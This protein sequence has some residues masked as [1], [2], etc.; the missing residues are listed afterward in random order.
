MSMNIEKIKCVI[1]AA[2]MAAGSSL[3]KERMV[4]LF[5]EEEKVQTADVTKALELLQ[6]E[7]E[8]RGVELIEVATGY[9]YQARQDYAEWIAKLWEERPS[10]YSRALLETLALIAYRQPT[11]RSD[12]EQVRGVGV[13]S[14]IVKTLLEREWIRVVGHRDVP[15]KP[16]L[17]A[18]TKQFLDYFGLK[19]LDELPSL[20][21][22][23]DLDNLNPELKFDGDTEEKVD[24]GDEVGLG[25]A[26]THSQAENEDDS[27][28]ETMS[29]TSVEE[30]SEEVH[31]SLDEGT[32]EE[33]PDGF[34]ETDSFTPAENAEQESSKESFEAEDEA[35]DTEE[36]SK[37]L[38]N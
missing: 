7:T 9:R 35:D 36:Q 34:E 37:E 27:D 16:A 14:S 32:A 30:G 12:I 33:K 22:I 19:S 18:T 23:K 11:T 3:S 24:D 20:A 31:Q 2:L 21:E 1:E 25:N 6:K 26:G 29:E 8:G 5:S 15:G 38:Q 28:D 10:R 17:Y 4:Q 13:S